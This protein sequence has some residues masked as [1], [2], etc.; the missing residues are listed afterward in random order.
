[1]KTVVISQSNYIPWRGYFS[2]IKKAD[3]FIFLDG[4][5][6]TRRDWRN[7]NIIKTPTGPQWLTIPVHVKGKYFQPID[8]MRIA[9][10]DWLEKHIRAIDFN[11]RRAAAFDSIS[12]ELFE[13]FRSASV[14]ELLS[15][16][17]T[18]L[19]VEICRFLRIA[20]KIQKS[21]DILPRSELAM[22][23][24]TDRLLQLCLAVGATHYVS[25]PAA[26]AYMD[27]E[28]FDKAGIAVSWMD[29]SNL[30]EYP[31]CWGTFDSHVSIVDLLLNC[32]DASPGFL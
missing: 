4:V 30:V 16:V 15:Q 18:Y 25:G 5:Q 14:F 24:P 28:K 29:Y 13:V 9:D 8:E 32:G 12:V 1:M 10:S 11:Y 23:D 17:N 21:T 27:L 22:M 20:T 2:M 7:R 31:Q 19:I 6:Y 26:Q 3:E